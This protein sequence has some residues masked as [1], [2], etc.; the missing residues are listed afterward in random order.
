MTREKLSPE[1]MRE[2]L[3]E[4]RRLDMK[5]PTSNDIHK[6]SEQKKEKLRDE[7]DNLREQ[8]KDIETKYYDLMEP[9]DSEHKW[10]NTESHIHYGYPEFSSF[11]D[12]LTVMIRVVEESGEE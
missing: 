4:W 12:F 10:V 11:D 7:I 3:E 9:I 5:M 2:D 6:A 8:K 1:E